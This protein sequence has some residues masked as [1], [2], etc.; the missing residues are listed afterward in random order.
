MVCGCAGGCRDWGCR[1]V[2]GRLEEE[3]GE[4]MDDDVGHMFPPKKLPCAL[5]WHPSSPEPP[6]RNLPAH[7]ARTR[8]LEVSLLSQAESQGPPRMS[9]SPQRHAS[10]P[11]PVWPEHISSATCMLCVT[12]A[13]SSVHG[14]IS[15]RQ[16]APPAPQGPP[17]HRLVLVSPPLPLRG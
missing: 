9:H 5:A 6:A 4:W 15:A 10:H 3:V 2:A 1:A 17:E 12:S 7:L 8:F 16:A 13:S 14:L 11:A